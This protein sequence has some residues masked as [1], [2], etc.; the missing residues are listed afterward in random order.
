MKV[1]CLWIDQTAGLHAPPA[2]DVSHTAGLHCRCWG[3]GGER[4]R[5]PKWIL[6]T[7]LRLW[8]RVR[9]EPHPS[10][11]SHTTAEGCF[12]SSLSSVSATLVGP[13]QRH[14]VSC[15]S[16][17]ET[18]DLQGLRT[19]SQALLAKFPGLEVR[20][21]HFLPS[22]HNSKDGQWGNSTIQ[23]LA[24]KVMYLGPFTFLCLSFLAG[25]TRGLSQS[26]YILLS[27]PQNPGQA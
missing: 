24:L 8:C 18:A 5:F 17:L 1:L 7:S 11:Q 6:E 23:E 26:P 13:T 10:L 16:G 15:S 25:K 3:W 2:V 22:I 9:S 14:W 27:T 20:N 19:H 4:A 21:G 12:T